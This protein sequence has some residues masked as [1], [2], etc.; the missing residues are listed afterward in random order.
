MH[1]LQNLQFDNYLNLKK[2]RLK[3]LSDLNIIIGPNNCGKTSILRGINILQKLKFGRYSP[4]TECKDCEVIFRKNPQI[5]SVDGELSQREGYLGIPKARIVFSFD[6]NEV[7][8]VFPH[9]IEKRNNILRNSETFPLLD[10]EEL[11]EIEIIPDKKKKLELKDELKE[12]SRHARREYAKSDIKLTERAN[13]K[14]VA[15]HISFLIDRQF[16]EEALQY[17]LLCPDARLQSY[18]EV[19]IPQ[20]VSS[21]NL[22]ASEQRRLIRFLK[23]MIDSKMID[24]RHNLDLVRDVDGNDFDTAIAEQGS[25]VK[26]LICLVADIISERRNKILLVDEPELGLNPAGKHAFLK[27]LLK[28]TK[29]TQIFLATHDPT[30]VNPIL[31]SKENVSIYIFSLIND[32]FVKVN[33]TESQEDPNTFAGYLPHTTSL[34]QIHMY[35]EGSLDVH[36][37]QIFLEKY[38]K[39]KFH[40]WYQIVNKVGIYHLAGDFWSH[41]LYTIPKKPY[42]AIVILDGDKIQLADEALRKYNAIEKDRFR[43]FDSPLEIKNIPKVNDR[44][45]Y[46]PVYCLRKPDIEDYLDPKPTSK[47]EGPII[48]QKMSDVPKEIKNIFEAT[49]RFANIKTDN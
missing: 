48:A 46:C 25:G 45:E 42:S 47:A 27:F 34:K 18:K 38:A 2:A 12:Q 23:D 24:I 14:L 31:W 8:K 10:P 40:K 36:I 22:S 30:F 9:V 33:L 7:E 49:F 43:M 39:E 28:Q 19:D 16:E 5:L 1:L 15:Q 6:M 32:D 11:A 29:E 37:F 41:L 17:I 4:S 35:V 13:Q 21:K 44:S 26:S 3:S 20:Y